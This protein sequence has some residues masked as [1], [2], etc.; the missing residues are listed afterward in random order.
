MLC[1][2]FRACIDNLTLPDS[3]RIGAKLVG[4]AGATLG[5]G[6]GAGGSS[7]RS[8]SQPH[9]AAEATRSVAAPLYP[10]NAAGQARS[11]RRPRLAGIPAEPTGS[12]LL[13][14]RTP[15]PRNLDYDE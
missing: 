2:C 15:L 4:G 1:T 9:S 8:N 11:V 10:R 6:A 7:E 12:R 13:L 14:L 5:A 3:N